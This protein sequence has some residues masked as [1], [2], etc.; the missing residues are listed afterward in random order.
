MKTVARITLK[1]GDILGEDIMSNHGERLYSKGTKLDMKALD[2]LARHNIMA[3]TIMEDIDFAET[4]TE[5]VKASDGFKAFKAA[6]YENVPVFRRILDDLVIDHTSP[7]LDK[8]MGV[9]VQLA[10]KAPTGEKL[11]EYLVN[12]PPDMENMIYEH[13]LNCGLI[14]SVFGN[15]LGLS[16]QELFV[17]IQC[18]FL[19]DVGKLCL[20]KDLIYKPSK[21]TDEEF[22]LMKTHTTLGSDLLREVGMSEQIAKCALEHHEKGDG[23]GYPGH[24]LINDI[25]NF[26]QY[27]SIIDAYEAMSAPKTYRFPL[28]VFEI[29]SNFQKDSA[30]YNKMKLDAVLFHIASTQMG[31]HAKLNDGR[32]GDVIYINNL[33]CGRPMLRDE[34]GQIIDLNKEPDSIYIYALF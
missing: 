17:F 28:N 32:E 31:L 7:P 9:Y 10:A 15:W 14:A 4:H 20:P 6:Y 26:A 27:M 33:N 23:S 19:Y 11:L 8:L 25:D 18:G 1:A 5:K 30:K 34:E 3:V 24:K 16:K 13:M 12:I 21:L 2:R 22:A 29:I